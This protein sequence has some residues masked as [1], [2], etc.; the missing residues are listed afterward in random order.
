MDI[1]EG[2]LCDSGCGQLA[3]FFSDNTGRYRCCKSASSCPA[4]KKKNSEGL[5]QA[6]IKG[7]RDP[8]KSF[9]EDDREKSNIAKRKYLIETKKFDELGETMRRKI[10]L[11]DQDYCCLHCGLKEWMGLS[12]TLEIDHID[13]CRTNNSRENL[14]ALCPNCHSIT[15]TWKVGNSQSRGKRKKSDIEIIEAWNTSTSMN[16][17]L[18]KLDMGWGSEPTVSRVLNQYNIKK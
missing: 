1:P 2:K 7:I 4:N 8:S 6:Y 9:T 5:K 12:I 17:T 11:E 16:E 13:G 3:N 15:D 18:K 10:I 14:R